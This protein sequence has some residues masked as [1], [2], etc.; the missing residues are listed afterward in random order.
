[1][2][3]S[4]EIRSYG[5]TISHR[6]SHRYWVISVITISSQD[7]SAEIILLGLFGTAFSGNNFDFGTSIEVK[8]TVSEYHNQMLPESDTL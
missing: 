7:S 5:L 8:R 2:S 4:T 1:M 6:A 3:F